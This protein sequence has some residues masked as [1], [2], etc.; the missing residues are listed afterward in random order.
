MDLSRAPYKGV[1]CFPTH[2]KVLP[3]ELLASSMEKNRLAFYM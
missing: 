1:T 2:M 3:R